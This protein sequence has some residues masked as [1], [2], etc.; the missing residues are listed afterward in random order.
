MKL[1]RLSSLAVA[2]ASEIR[3]LLSCPQA[4]EDAAGLHFGEEPLPPITIKRLATFGRTRRSRAGFRRRRCAI[5]PFHFSTSAPTAIAP[6]RFP[7]KS[8]TTI[9]P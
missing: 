7:Q 3:A 9:H 1:D 5:H 2:V 6:R 8:Q 4:Y